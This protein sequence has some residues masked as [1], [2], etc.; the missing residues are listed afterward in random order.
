MSSRSEGVRK[1]LLNVPIEDLLLLGTYFADL[2]YW[3]VSLTNKVLCVGV[4]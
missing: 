3:K 1:N 4:K 2:F